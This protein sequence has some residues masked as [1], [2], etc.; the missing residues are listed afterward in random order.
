MAKEFCLNGHRRTPENIKLSNGGCKTC[1]REQEAVWRIAQGR[2]PHSR[3]PHGSD[4]PRKGKSKECRECHRM[5]EVRRNRRRG[6][7]PRVPVTV[8]KRGHV[9]NEENC[10]PGRNLCAICHRLDERERRAANREE[11]N[12][13]AREYARNHKAEA[14]VRHKAWRDAN[15]E[16]VKAYAREAQASRQGARTPKAKEFIK[17][18]RA[19]PC[20]YCGTYGQVMHLDHVDPVRHG[21]SKTWGNL[22]AACQRCNS[23]KKDK[24]LLQFMLRVALEADEIRFDALDALL[25]DDGDVTVPVV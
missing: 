7:G 22:T 17:I 13:I 14:R 12:R 15:P 6:V 3:C 2:K 19:D 23:R 9:L 11:T 4:A 24:S 1:R 25:K 18:L 10:R 20:S 16:H 5:G 8:C 21:G